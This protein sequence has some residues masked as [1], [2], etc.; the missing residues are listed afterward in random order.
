MSFHSNYSSISTIH[1]NSNIFHCRT[2]QFR[3]LRVE[4]LAHASI[5]D[6]QGWKISICFGRV[7]IRKLSGFSIGGWKMSHFHFDVHPA[8]KFSAIFSFEFHSF[9]E[10]YHG[11]GENSNRKR[12]NNKLD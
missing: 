7:L 4:I 9:E 3:W 1:A 10:L 8:L 11:K 5:S 12:L 6:G 2:Q